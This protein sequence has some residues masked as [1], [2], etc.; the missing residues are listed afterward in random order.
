MGFDPRA[1]AEPDGRAG[2]AVPCEVLGRVPYDGRALS[3]SPVPGPVEF[4]PIEGLL[5]VE[6]LLFIRISTP[7]L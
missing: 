5:G 4:D 6:A 1:V 7:R 2:V 3:D